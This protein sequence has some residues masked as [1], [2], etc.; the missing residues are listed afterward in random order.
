M[1]GSMCGLAGLLSLLA[2]CLAATAARAHEADNASARI[3]EIYAPLLAA[4]SNLAL[5]PKAG[6]FPDAPA[7]A[8]KHHLVSANLRTLLWRDQ[9]R[10]EKTGERH[11]DFDFLFN[12]QDTCEKPLK[13]LGIFPK[14]NTYIMKISN[15]CEVKPGLDQPY[16][17]ILVQEAGRWVIDDAQYTDGKTEFTLSSILKGK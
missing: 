16:Y 9:R 4:Y 10:A 14:N 1:R 2:V 11:L 8:L 15:G 6:S 13:I 12:G 5:R 7:F 3:R 17:F